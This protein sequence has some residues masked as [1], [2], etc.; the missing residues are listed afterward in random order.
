MK[1]YLGHSILQL[2]YKGQDSL[3]KFVLF[4]VLHHDFTA[5]LFEVPLPDQPLPSLPVFQQSA[6][7]QIRLLNTL[8][9][10]AL[11][12][13]REGICLS[14]CNLIAIRVIKLG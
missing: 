13:S 7:I 1:L 9:I 4:H 12:T 2:F 10:L 3:S 14:S 5:L 8:S 6:Q 11:N